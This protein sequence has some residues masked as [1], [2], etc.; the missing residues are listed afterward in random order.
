MNKY[1]IIDTETTGLN[2]IMDKPFLI[3]Y[4]IVNENLNLIESKVIDL[5][6]LIQKDYDTFLKYLETIPT[7][8]GHNIKFD[9]HMLLNIGVDFNLLITKNYIDTSVLARLIIS[10]DT[11]TD[12][13]FLTSLKILSIRYLGIN[14]A[15]EERKLKLELSR[16][17]SEHKQRMRDYFIQ[18]NIWFTNISRTEDTKRLNEI[19]NSW[20]KIYHKYPQFKKLRSIFLK[21][22]KPPTYADCSNV[23]TYALTDIRLTHGLFKLWYPKI[24]KLQ[25]Q[26]AFERISKAVIPLLL[27]ERQGLTVDL[28]QLLK[29]RNK[30]ITEYNKTKLIDPRNG[31]QLTIGQHAKLKEVYEYE[32]GE[33]LENADKFTR[34]EIE[35]VSATAKKASYIAKM[36]KYLTTYI[37]GILNKLTIHNTDYKIYT[38]YNLAGTITGRLSS[39]F[40]QFPKE[41]L[42]LNDNTE[43]NIRSWFITPSTHKYM[44]YFDYEQMELRL[45]CEWTGIVNKEPDLN[46][47][48]AFSPYK[49]VL[50]NNKYYL[51]EDTTIEWTPIDLHGLTTKHAFPNIDETHSD[52]DHYR[53]LG[54]RTNFAVNYGAAAPRIQQALHVDF[55]TA[56]RLVDGYKQAFKGVVDFVKWIGRRVYVTDNIPNLLM[57]RYYSRNKHQLQNWLVQGSGADIL[58]LKLAEVYEYIKNKSHWNFMICVHD[59][60]G[61]VCKDI[62][63]KQLQEEVKEIQNI[64]TYKLTYVNLITSVEYTTTKWSQQ[65]KWEEGE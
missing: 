39:D 11:Q 60:I 40:Q 18:Q 51:E 33:T 19:Y 50:N 62:P 10:H 64:L 45:Q 28:P 16:L 53:S 65:L 22:D 6:N 31:D 44:F 55:S 24:I 14:C 7:I 32:V 2:I 37:T 42:I 49:C 8:I 56:Q 1:L 61:F 38:Q 57:R 35:S 27:M 21:Q 12:K 4:G 41:S 9:L 36:D 17:T 48:R 26:Y 29:D 34:D 23:R 54:K 3:Q 15:D 58:L 63:S 30:I 59:E 47:A 46:L 43:I 5:R 13:T 25:Q 20:N 52:W